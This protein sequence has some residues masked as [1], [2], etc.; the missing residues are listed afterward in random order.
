MYDRQVQQHQDGQ[1]LQ[2][3]QDQQQREQGGL[4]QQQQGG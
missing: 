4:E 3:G 2:G 1:A